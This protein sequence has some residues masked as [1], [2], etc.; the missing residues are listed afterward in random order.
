MTAVADPV[1]VAVAFDDRV[2]GVNENDFVPFQLAVF[3]YPVGVQDFHVRELPACTLFSDPLDAL[4]CSD[5]VLTHVMGT[6]AAHIPGPSKTSSAHLYTG[7]NYALFRLVTKRTCTVDTC[8]ASYLCNRALFSPFLEPF[9]SELTDV[10]GVRVL[11]CVSYI[12][13]K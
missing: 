8:R 11:P 3:A 7:N 6:S 2:A 5:L 4:S 10:S 12:A 1:K 13:V 9:P